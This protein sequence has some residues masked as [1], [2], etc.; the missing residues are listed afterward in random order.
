MKDEIKE[1]LQEIKET[2]DSYLET[3]KLKDDMMYD[4]INYKASQWYALLD[5]ITNLQE[6]NERLKKEIPS[7]DNYVPIENQMRIS[8]VSHEINYQY[9]KILYE[10]ATKDIVIDDLVYKCEDLD[11]LRQ[12]Y[13]KLYIEKE[14][15][16]SRNEKAIEY[17]EKYDVFKEFTFPLMK[18][19]EENQVKSSID[20]Q[21]KKDLKKNLLNILQG[22]GKDEKEKE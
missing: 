7:P 5:Y 1:M 9:F 18:R 10:K 19:D 12:S 13:E 6:E 3:Y 2:V 20:Y 17:L 22:V 11:N 8:S 15:Y 4:T 14:D 16:K 21:F